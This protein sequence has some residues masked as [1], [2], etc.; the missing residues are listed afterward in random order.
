MKCVLNVWFVYIYVYHVYNIAYFMESS[1]CISADSEYIPSNEDIL[2]VYKHTT[3]NI[4]YDETFE[5]ENIR[6]RFIELSTDETLS[7][8]SYFC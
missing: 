5:I 7:M 8:L 6:F 4:D 1:D 2:R 3:S